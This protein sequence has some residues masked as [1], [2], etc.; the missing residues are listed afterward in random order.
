MISK[1]EN[2]ITDKKITGQYQM[3]IK[4]KFLNKILAK[5]KKIQQHI[6]SI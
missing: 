6:K 5:K 3:N 2:H 1:A 4:V